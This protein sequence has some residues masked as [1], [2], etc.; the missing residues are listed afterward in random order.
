M[1]RS[2]LCDK[3]LLLLLAMALLSASPWARAQSATRSQASP[4]AQDQNLEQ[5]QAQE[6]DQQQSPAEEPD[7]IQDEGRIGSRDQIQG[8]APF[9]NAPGS[10]ARIVR[11]SYID[12]EVR[13]DHGDG[14]ESATM[15]VPIT[16]HNWLQTRSDGWAEVQMED[17]SLIRLAPD[18]VMAFTDL[19]RLSSGGTVTTVD[20]DQGEAE[21]KIAKRDE[22]EFQVTVKNKSIVLDHSSS[23][24]VTSTNADPLEIAVWKGEV[25]VRDSES[26]GEVAVKKNETFALDPTDVAQYALDKGAEADQLDDWSKQRDEALSTYASASHGAFQSPYQYGTG[27]LNYYGNYFDAPGYGMVWQPSGVNLGWDPF[28]NGYWVFSPGFGYTWVSSYPWGWL[29]FRYGN[30]VY[31]NHRGWCWAPGGWTRWN[32]G[33]RWVNAPPGFRPPLPP[34]NGTVVVGGSP[35]RVIRPGNAWDRG[36]SHLG[37][38]AADRDDPSTRANRRVFT[39]DDMERVPRTDIPATQS[40]TSGAIG[41]EH[42]ANGGEQH[43]AP[44]GTVRQSWPDRQQRIPEADRH[45]GNSAVVGSTRPAEVPRAEKPTPPTAQQAAPPAQPT[46]QQYTPPPAPAVHQSAPPP[47]VHPAPAAAPAPRSFSPPASAPVGHSSG[48]EAAHGGGRP[49]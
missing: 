47:A 45:A 46:R 37:G 21:F 29:P 43:P 49:K 4:Q 24:R 41:S 13:I 38:R 9:N 33:P 11:I 20:L 30:W 44:K 40:S 5:I 18:T 10:Q 17:G 19:R 6:Q 48:G 25:S 12:G 23:F 8:A 22:N 1:R 35:G 15:N 36:G 39:N 14:Y 34:A 26:G 32:T 27:D 16:E 7:R 42:T 28:M 31:I 2:I 3:C